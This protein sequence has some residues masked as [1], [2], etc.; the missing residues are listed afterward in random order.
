MLSRIEELQVEIFRFRR[1]LDSLMNSEDRMTT[2]LQLKKQYE[3]AHVEFR[4]LQ[5]Q[6]E[7]KEEEIR[8]QIG[9]RIEGGG[10]F[11]EQKWFPILGSMLKISAK[12]LIPGTIDWWQRDEHPF[13]W[14]LS[15]MEKKFLEDH[16][17]LTKLRNVANEASKRMHEM[18]ILY[19]RYR[20]EPLKIS[21]K[22][23]NLEKEIAQI[24]KKRQSISATI[25]ENL[26]RLRVSVDTA[27]NVI[28]TMEELP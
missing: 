1:K 10:P 26:S 6:F 24:K 11:N 13:Q 20:E 14:A 19:E 22:I 4:K 12:E 3:K 8:M 25:V 17:E 23:S 7:V 5:S 27:K 21:Q 2:E 15:Q 16:P 18:M 9:F 28:I